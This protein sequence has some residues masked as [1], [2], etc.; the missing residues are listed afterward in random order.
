MALKPAGG[1]DHR[2]GPWFIAGFDGTCPCSAGI[3]EGDPVRYLDGEVV[4]EECG[5]SGEVTVREPVPSL[6]P[7]CHQELSVVDVRRGLT[8]HEECW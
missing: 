2:I 8:E 1:W 3:E 7:L 6:C 5:V 4:C